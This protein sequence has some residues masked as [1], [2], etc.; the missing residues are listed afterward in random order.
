MKPLIA[1]ITV[2]KWLLR[3]ALIVY[4]LLFNYD[5]LL[6]F[7]FLEVSFV[8]A[9]IYVFG[10][11]ALL[12]GGFRKDSNITVYASFILLVAIGFNVY[13]DVKDGFFGLVRHLMPMSIAFHFLSNGNK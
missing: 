13:F 5:T 8:F 3:F 6:Y 10:A 1:G 12:V 9:A 7:D 11:I 4:L 2:S